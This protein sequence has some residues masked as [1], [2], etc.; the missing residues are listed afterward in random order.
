MLVLLI[1]L[2]LA[3]TGFAVLFNEQTGEFTSAL[4][5]KDID[6]FWLSIQKS[7]GILA[8]GVPAFGFYYYVRDLLALHWRRWRSVTAMTGRMRSCIF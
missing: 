7:L 8:F 6:R 3:Q 1:L 5:A 4:A 2:L